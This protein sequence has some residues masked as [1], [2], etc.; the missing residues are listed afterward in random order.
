MPLQRADS[1]SGSCSLVRPPSTAG[2]RR[3]VLIIVVIR[4]LSWQ[5]LLHLTGL[6]MPIVAHPHP[7][8]GAAMAQRNGNLMATNGCRSDLR[9]AAEQ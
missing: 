4:F 9:K 8:C 5:Q 1:Y 7:D 3:S 6:I 2:A